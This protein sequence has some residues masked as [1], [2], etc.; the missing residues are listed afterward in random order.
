MQI[1]LRR[2]SY[3]AALSHE[4][5]AFTADIWIDGRKAGNA[6]NH[7]TGGCTNI[8]PHALQQRLDEYGKTLPQVDIGS[9][10]GG[11]PSLIAQDG[12]W[13][14]G[15]LLDDWILLRDLR[16]RLRNRLLYVRNGEHGI[17]QSK[18]LQP[19]QLTQ[20]LGSA[21]IREKWNVATF[22]N[23]VPEAEALALYR[24]HA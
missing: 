11:E 2:I 18:V 24:E 1:E 17:M 20:I 14:V 19:A 12:E 15:R 3:S 16:R 4:T 23:S 10:S 22:L 8:H 6:E 21:E 13:I 9:M 5:R 7:G